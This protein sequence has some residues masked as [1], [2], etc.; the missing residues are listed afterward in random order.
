MPLSLRWFW[1]LLPKNILNTW[2]GEGE[3]D[4]ILSLYF[5]RQV[6]LWWV[7]HTHYLMKV[8]FL[9]ITVP[10]SQ[11][12]QRLTLNM[13]NRISFLTSSLSNACFSFMIFL[14]RFSSSGNSVL[15][16]PLNKKTQAKDINFDNSIFKWPLSSG[17]KNMRCVVICDSIVLVSYNWLYF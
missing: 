13:S 9:K 1:V 11:L 15:D 6:L 12:L 4:A 17:L 3:K 8:A 5:T 7:S 16:T 14:Q 10:E 2:E